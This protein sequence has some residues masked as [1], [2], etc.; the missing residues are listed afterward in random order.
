MLL[1]QKVLFLLSSRDD[2]IAARFSLCML[3]EFAH[4][5]EQDAARCLFGWIA[6]FV[7]FMRRERGEQERVSQQ[8][9]YPVLPSRKK[10]G[11][12]CE[13]NQCSERNCVASLIARRDCTAVPGFGGHPYELPHGRFLHREWLSAILGAVSHAETMQLDHQT[14]K[15]SSLDT[16]LN[17]GIKGGFSFILSFPLSVFVSAW[18][19]LKFRL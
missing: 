4:M 10:A 6:K 13:R 19:R 1:R 14:Q 9:R 12:C 11:H 2:D 16:Q 15:R 3:C 17:A 7:R 5:L 8:W 18:R